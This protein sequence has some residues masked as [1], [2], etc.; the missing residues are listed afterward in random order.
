MIRFLEGFPDGTVAVEA[1]GRVTLE[2][3]D[4]VLIPAVEDAL[5]KHG[6][7]RLY[8]ELGKAFSGIDPGAAWRD[9]R[10]GIEHLSAWERMALVTDIEWIRLAV[11]AFSFLMP[12]NLRV[13]SNSDAARAR[14]WIREP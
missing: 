2:D 13:F 9:L 10:I 8:Y 11:N 4:K 14:A 3:Y 7:V 5:E 1:R 6:K 12:G